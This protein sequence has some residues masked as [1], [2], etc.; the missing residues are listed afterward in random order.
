MRMAKAFVVW[1]LLG[2]NSGR[3]VMRS[4][5]VGFF[6]TCLPAL[7]AHGSPDGKGDASPNYRF[8]YDKTTSVPD[9][10][11]LPKFLDYFVD[12]LADEHGRI[13][14][15]AE[16]KAR[17]HLSTDEEANAFIDMMVDLNSIIQADNKESIRDVV[18]P[19][20]MPRPTGKDVFIALD[21]VD[22]R[23]DLVSESVLNDLR[24]HL[25]PEAFRYFDEWMDVVKLQSKIIRIDHSK[26]YQ[27]RNPDVVRQSACAQVDN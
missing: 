26:M 11:F 10:V 24:R 16:A 13:H 18:C 22:D 12:G 27:G 14:A 15:L 23:R 1:A 17:M 2:V 21:A 20:D 3:L 8:F 4:L 7:Y 6:F 25:G 5:V 9:K 19:L